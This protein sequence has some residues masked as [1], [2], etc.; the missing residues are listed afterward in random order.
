MQ[1]NYLRK[2]RNPEYDRSHKTKDLQKVKVCLGSQ[3][4]HFEVVSKSEMTSGYIL[5]YS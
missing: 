3:H 5:D 4:G 1:I 2:M